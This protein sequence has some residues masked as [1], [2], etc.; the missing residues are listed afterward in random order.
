[1]KRICLQTLLLVVILLTCG[2]SLFRQG[3]IKVAKEHSA[4]AVALK[5]AS[6]SLKDSWEFYSGCLEALQPK[7]SGKVWDIKTALD[8]I[9]ATGEWSDRAAGKTLTLR[10]L[11][12]K[13]LGQDFIHDALPGFLDLF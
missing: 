6:D 1:M 7:L 8:T 3:A 9:Y 13:E 2:C 4:N 10:L 5:E 11:L 12:I